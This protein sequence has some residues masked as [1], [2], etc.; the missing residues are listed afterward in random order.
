MS[1]Y[2]IVLLPSVMLAVVG[3]SVQT[4]SDLNQMGLAEYRAGNYAHAKAY[5]TQ[6]WEKDRYRPVTLYN[7]G[8]CAMEMARERFDGGNVV[9]AL[10]YLDDA[11][12]WFDS[13]IAAFPGYAEAQDAKV[14]ALELQGNYRSALAE[15]EWIDENVG[16]AARQKLVL[17]RH[18]ERRGDA[19]QAL[20]CYRQAVAMQPES[21]YA[22]AELGKFYMRR[23]QTE[24][25][26][27]ELQI[28]YQLN[29]QQ[30]GVVD[31]LAELGASPTAQP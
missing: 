24:N 27:A 16:P 29:W 12:G 2:A 26:I 19:D 28:A 30:P 10:R 6:A 20:L 4:V 5:F 18:H 9:G 3:C 14:R 15:A 1:R 22:H 7:L 21:A 17:A 31:S 23:G 11:I 8:S 13:A 25:A